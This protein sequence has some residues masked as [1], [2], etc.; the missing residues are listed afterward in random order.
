[1]LKCSVRNFKERKKG[2]KETTKTHHVLYQANSQFKIKHIMVSTSLY[3]YM[4][5]IN[6]NQFLKSYYRK[7]FIFFLS[8]QG[9][10][11]LLEKNVKIYIKML[12]HVSI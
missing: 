8:N 3:K 6:D 1:M 11:R 7:S 9:T 10:I 12:L 4:R 2:K 5:L